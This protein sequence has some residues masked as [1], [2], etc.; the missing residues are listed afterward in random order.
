MSNLPDRNNNP[1]NLKDFNTGQFRQFKSPQEGYAALLNDI[2][3]KIDGKSSSGVNGSSTLFDFSK[4][5][6]PA[7]DKNNPAKYAADLANSL[8]VRPDTPIGELKSRVGDFAQAI[9]RNEGF[10]QASGFQA[11]SSDQPKASNDD[12]SVLNTAF[13][14]G[15]QPSGKKGVFSKILGGVGA[16]GNALFPIV[17]DVYQDVTGKS[18]KN[19]KQQLADLAMSALPFVPGL[20]EIGAVGKAAEGVGALSKVAKVARV[21]APLAEGYGV[22]TIQNVAEGKGLGESL[23]P[24]LNNLGG[25]AFGGL[26][27]GLLKGGEATVDSISGIPG[28][29]KPVLSELSDPKLYDQYINAA[30]ARASDVRNASPLELAADYT[31]KAATGIQQRLKQI[32]KVV[33]EVKKTEGTKALKP[34]DSVLKNFVTNLEDKFGLKIST[35]KFGKRIK[36]ENA[37]GRV[38]NVLTATDQNRVKRA[39]SEVLN[40]RKSGNIRKASDV[41]D[42]LDNLVDYSKKDLL[43][44]SND[45]LEGFLKSIRHDLNGVV[46]ESSPALAQA[47]GRFHDL[48]DS[49]EEISGAGGDNLQRA[50]LLLKRVLAGDKSEASRKVFDIIKKETGIDL[51]EHAVLADH[52]IRTIKDPSQISLLNKMIENV[53]QEGQPTAFGTGLNVTKGLMRKLFAN[54]ETIGRNLANKKGSGLIRSLVKRE[55]T[56]Q[57]ARIPGLISPP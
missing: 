32:G 2:Q 40:L 28:N 45:P 13:A 24:N 27:H 31:K 7:S 51:V 14:S 15:S 19:R 37:S 44:H 11:T 33:G 57:S 3:G 54:P 25:A 29:I 9:A 56:T 23:K 48:S 42:N 43:G 20:G 22:G 34:V 49:L 50:E 53:V 8:G 4:A 5:W 12:P 41:I 6:A 21:A 39:L 10:S 38:K 16:V 46:G 17:K 55:F 36:I 26:A 1:G 30:K 18:T 52:A 47:K 35:N